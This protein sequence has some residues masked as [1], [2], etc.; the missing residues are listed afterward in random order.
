VILHS[1][2]LTY[3]GRFRETVRLGPF[4]SGLNVLAAPNESGKSTALHAAARALFD[5]HTTRSEE[6]KA[7]QPA[8]TSLAPRVVVEFET[9]AG[10]FRLSKTFLQK[11]ESQLHQQRAGSWELIA[12]A[13]AAD[14]R[15]QTLL[16]SSLPGRGATKPEHWGFLGFLWAR[17]GEPTLWPGLDDADVGQRI[18]ARLARVELDPVIEQLR[19]RLATAAEAIITGTGQ[20]RAGGPLRQAEDDLAAI[21]TN[22]V[23]LRQTR[24]ELDEAL[25]RFQQSEAEV[26]RLEKEHAERSAAAATLRDQSLAAERLRAQLDAHLQALATSQEKLTTVTTDADTL[27]RLEREQAETQASLAQARASA[28]SAERALQEVRARLDQ[29]QSDQPRHEAALQLLRAGHQRLQS[30]IKLRDLSASSAGLTKQLKKAEAA[31]AA[32]AAL[33]A[34]KTQLPALAPAKL[35]K[36]EE[37]AESVHTLRTRLQALGLTVELTPDKKTTVENRTTPEP[38]AQTLPAGKTTRLQSPQALDLQLVGWG[39]LVVRSGSHDAQAVATDL[40]DAEADLQ[41]SLQQAGVSTLAAAREAV[42]ARKD[43]EGQLKTATAALEP[44][45][46]DYESLENLREAVALA[47]RRAEAQTASLVPTDADQ[48]RSLT[49]LEAADAAQAE[50][51]TAADSALATFSKQLAKLRTEDRA[52]SQAAQQANKQVSDHESRTRTLEAQAKGIADRYPD[53]IAGAKTVAQL[54]FAQAEARVVAT[55]SELPPDFEKLPERNKRAAASLQQIANDLQAR[56]TARDQAQATLEILGGQGLYSRETDLEEKKAE[57]LLRRDA[58]RARGWSARV[59]HDL[60][61]HRKQAATKAVLAPLEHRLT[62]AFAELTGDTARQVFLDE[63]LQIA[64]IGR[65]RDE[66]FAFDQLSQGAKEQLLL[67]LRLAVAQELA[68]DEPQVLILDDVLVN[69]DPVRQDRVLDVLGAQAARLQILILTC[70][71]DR[72]RGVG[73]QINFSTLCNSPTF[74]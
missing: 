38:P 7:L 69:T 70:H 18:R 72:Y 51:V 31:S 16:Q 29:A 5:R 37:L 4:A 10:R 67:C 11:P 3:V 73:G 41:E 54:A 56:R 44:H 64:G 8:G 62:T 9:R 23:S 48:A 17:Q 68:T 1:L 43:L 25:R 28:Q 12:D 39:R 2:E 21:E 55:R 65:S 63:R 52:A 30:L 32:I 47:A 40:A 27:A 22:L 60:I 46:G 24:T 36:L 49:D 34:K 59:A 66:A 57:A 20:S 19:L 6:I 50:S 14:Q 13:D 74:V 33:E 61:E 26:A 71:P 58:A 53:G 15:V 45:L 42:T 35:R